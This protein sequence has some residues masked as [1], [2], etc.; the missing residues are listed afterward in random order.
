MVKLTGKIQCNFPSLVS[1][2]FQ[3]LTLKKPLLPS[4]GKDPLT[5]LRK[6]LSLKI[7]YLG[8]KGGCLDL[9]AVRYALALARKNNCLNRQRPDKD[10]TTT[11]SPDQFKVGNLVYIK[12][13]PTPLG[14]PNRKVVFI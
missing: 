2:Y 8:D 4:F 7:R 6:L 1:G 3:V 10:H 9:E 5:P 11:R 12:T 13:M 14:N